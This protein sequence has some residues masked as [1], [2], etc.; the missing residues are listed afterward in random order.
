MYDQAGLY[1]I[2]NNI[3]MIAIASTTL[4]LFVRMKLDCSSLKTDEVVD[5]AIFL[6]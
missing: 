6:L 1:K 4:Y 2:Q 5:S 3:P